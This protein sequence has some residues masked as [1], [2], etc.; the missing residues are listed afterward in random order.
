M[1][2]RK[3]ATGENRFRTKRVFGLIFS[4]L[5]VI[6]VVCAGPGVTS[7]VATAAGETTAGEAAAETVAVE[8]T[9]AAATVAAA[10]VNDP[11]LTVISPRNVNYVTENAFIGS[12][13][14]SASFDA[15]LYFPKTVSVL[16]PRDGMFVSMNINSNEWIQEGD[17][18]ATFS[19][20]PNDLEI[21]EAALALE[22]AESSQRRWIESLE[23][24]LEDA[25]ARLA[26]VYTS[27]NAIELDG[28]PNTKL[29]EYSVLAAA[30]NLDFAKYDG[31]RNL[32]FMRERLENLREENENFT[33]YAPISGYVYDVV[34][35]SVG[36]SVPGGQFVCRI[37]NPEVFQLIIS[38]TNLSQ[39]RLGAEV[40]I[41]TSRRD[42][43]VFAGRVIGNTT[44]LDRRESESRA[45]VAFSNQQEF[46]DFVGDS[47]QRVAGLRYRVSIRQADI[48]NVLLAPRRA[49]STESAYR[50]VNVLEDGLSKK[51][52][53]L[54]GLSNMEYIQILD[55]ISAGDA[56][57]MN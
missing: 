53:V 5:L 25:V 4:L 8:T 39:L 37:S 50:F 12:L 2:T 48:R 46:I 51:R 18:I 14:R 13:E 28:D 33:I 49:V 7:A 27:S 56:L 3:P 55:G 31:E 9:T 17:P 34:Y 45:V 21:D 1:S 15:R 35:F 20:V 29:A 54:V 30:E 57:I 6:Y 38:A 23:A 19:V 10:V 52:Y 36:R 24:A 42:A 32:D 44:L 22:L 26:T 40:S 16:V 41:E 11:N 47:V 43:P